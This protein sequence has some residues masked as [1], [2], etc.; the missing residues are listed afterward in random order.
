[1]QILFVYPVGKQKNKAWGPLWA[2]ALRE[3]ARNAKKRP[4][5][6]SRA[7]LRVLEKSDFLIE[8]GEQQDALFHCAGLLGR[9]GRLGGAV[10]DGVGGQFTHPF[11]GP[12]GDLGFVLEGL[13][14]A[15]AGVSALPVSFSMYCT[16]R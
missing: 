2:Q 5:E 12:I 14:R 8:T 3:Q 10:H 16:A 7:F 6:K 1:M 4:G 13:R 11:Y 9:S 15:A